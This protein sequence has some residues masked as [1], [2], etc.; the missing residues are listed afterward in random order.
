MDTLP[1][2]IIHR[3]F[4]HL[5]AQTILFSIRCLSRSFR[6]IVNS[7]E[8][9]TLDLKG[10]S[11][12]DFHL[13]CRLIKPENV[14]SL[15]LSN[16]FKHSDE[17]VSF[18]PYSRHKQFTRLRRLTL[19]NI[20]EGPL[21]F[22]LRESNL[23]SLTSFPV[24]FRRGDDRLAKTT[25]EFLASIIT[26]LKLEKLEFLSN[27]H[28]IFAKVDCP[29]LSTI[30]YLSIGYCI[31]LHILCH[32]LQCSLH[33][34]TLI[35]KNGFGPWYLTNMPK[36]YLSTTFSQVQSLTIENMYNEIDTVDELLSL[37]SSLNYLKIIF[38][39]NQMKSMPD[40]HYWEILIQSK[41]I[42][43][44]KFEFFF[45]QYKFI[46]PLEELES[47]KSTFQTSFWVEHKQ[48]FVVCEYEG[49]S[50]FYYR[51]YTLP[52]CTS[53]FKCKRSLKR[54]PSSAVTMMTENN[55]VKSIHEYYNKEEAMITYPRFVKATDLT[56]GVNQKFCSSL[57]SLIYQKVDVTKLLKITLNINNVDTMAEDLFKN[58]VLCIEQASNLS[59]LSICGRHINSQTY[60][61]MRNIYSVLPR[62]IK[63]L[64]IQIDNL[65]AVEEI[66]MRCNN[67]STVKFD[68]ENL[69]IKEITQ[70][71]IN[72]TINS[73]CWKYYQSIRVW[74]GKKR[75][76][77]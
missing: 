9:F 75:K 14:I 72:N 55:T 35:L 6:S 52:I 3:I 2:E 54:L 68:A 18:C 71:F 37:T 7:Y 10:L 61:N 46:K 77:N 40:G 73:I 48:W 47:M 76:S 66:L 29:V 32:I 36:S 1:V 24:K 56:I 16:E 39:C 23:T 60:S 57:L 31:S 74:L 27:I 17:I 41:L 44:N 8:R 19:E 38:T 4:D 64:E 11:Q 33:L 51:F 67:L 65:N 63:H 15:S 42:Q 12:Q 34:H 13:L 53:E 50:L 62:Q 28:Y 5:D 43:L 69:L 26:Q 25:E 70:W 30:R 20:D 22:L 21:K 49:T 58:F 59:S 45:D